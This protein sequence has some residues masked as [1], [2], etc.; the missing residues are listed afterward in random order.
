MEIKNNISSRNLEVFSKK[1]EISLYTPQN[2]TLSEICFVKILNPRLEGSAYYFHTIFNVG[3]DT[4]LG[5]TTGDYTYI[6]DEK[7]IEV[8]LLLPADLVKLYNHPTAT[9]H[10]RLPKHIEYYFKQ[11]KRLK[12]CTLL[13]QIPVKC[14]IK[15]K[16]LSFVGDL[17]EVYNYTPEDTSDESATITDT[18]NSTYND[19]SGSDDSDDYSGGGTDNS[20]GDNSNSNSDN[21]TLLLAAALV[22]LKFLK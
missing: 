18:D 19:G 21:K 10:G 14:Y 4:E 9:M 7:Y 3:E 6:N 20:G 13:F 2:G 16:D 15:E 5:F 11:K 1:E 12:G 17:G 8:E 22:I